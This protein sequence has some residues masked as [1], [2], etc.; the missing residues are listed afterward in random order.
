MLPRI[1]VLG[2]S[3]LKG[4]VFDSL[5]KRYRLLKEGVV[6]LFTR[7]TA[8]DVTNC[9]VFGATI[10]KG[11]QQLARRLDSLSGYSYALLEFGGNDCDFD[12]KAISENPSARHQ[13]NTSIED[14]IERYARLIDALREKKV[15]PVIMSLP[16]L[17]ADRFFETISKGLDRDAILQW[18]GGHKDTIYRWHEAYNLAVL[19]MAKQKNVP[20]IDVRS[21]FLIRPDYRDLLCD[22]GMHPNARGHRLILQTIMDFIRPLDVLPAL[23]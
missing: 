12:W 1:L 4:V 8:L 20:V 6:S 5:L 10:V 17:D 21:S 16:P 2:D 3:V 11:E 13:P 7:E 15:V 19:N 9:A 22:D 18:L 14:F 23:Q